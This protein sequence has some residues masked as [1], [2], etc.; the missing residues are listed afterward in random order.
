MHSNHRQ[1][2]ARNVVCVHCSKRGHFSKVCQTRLSETSASASASGD[3]AAISGVDVPSGVIA[4]APCWLGPAVI[5]RSIQGR[6]VDVL[7]DTG[8]SDNFISETTSRDLDL[9]L[10]ET[11]ECISMAKSDVAVKVNGRSTADI[12][13]LGCHYKGLQLGIIPDLCADVI[14]G[15]NFLAQ[16]SEVIIQ[17]GGNK[18]SLQISSQLALSALG[19][20]EA[21][22]KPVRIS[23]FIDPDC[24]PIATKSRRYSCEER[25]FIAEEITQ[26]L[27]AGII[28]PS[29]S[30][31]R[32]QVRPGEHRAQAVSTCPSHTIS[33][34]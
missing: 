3:L 7:I 12:E 29:R 25:Q 4:S 14:L 13:L 19:V 16:H 15:R 21:K 26:M 1:C 28:E 22:S 9:K 23:K 31:W 24:K 34:K 17:Y 18:P 6:P 32:A 2:P 33:K 30:P 10:K 5:Q 20:S 27:D 8:A 11:K